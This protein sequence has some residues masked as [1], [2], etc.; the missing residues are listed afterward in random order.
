MIPLS[1]DNP[2]KTAPVVTVAIIGLCA[3]AF[4]WELRF[5][6]RM[7]EALVA[8]GFTPSSFESGVP[9]NKVGLP[10][11]ATI[12]TAMFLHAGWLH[13]IGNMLFLWIFGNNI[14]DA[15]GHVRFTLFYLICG[16]AAALTMAMLDPHSN[17]PMIGASGAISGV[18]AAYMLLYPR[19]RVHTLLILGI[20]FYFA[21][22]RAVWV[23]GIWFAIQ[24][25][26]AVLTPPSEP[27]TAWWAHVGGFAM[28]LI[29]TP[30]FK[31]RDVPFFGPYDT[32]GPW[33]D[34]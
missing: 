3:L 28:G 13:I 7:D 16:V 23:V 24:L 22:L 33:A 21:R 9:L 20:L 14:E 2:S 30:L 6:P 12:F 31:S 17:T 29:L 11:W 25:V 19:A 10:V 8:F 1:D 5:G 32:R 18:L 26:T 34:G 27:G 4:I 15:M